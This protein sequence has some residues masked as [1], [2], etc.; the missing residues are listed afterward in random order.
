MIR[1]IGFGAEIPEKP[2]TWDVAVRVE[3]LSKRY[4]VGALHRR[5]D[6]LRDHIAYS[7]G[8]TLNRLLPGRPKE[9]DSVTQPA[10]WAI[11]DVS[12]EVNK[13]EVVGFIG[14]NGAGK[15][16]LLK[17]LSRVTKPTSGRAEIYGDSSSLLEVGTG[18]NGELTGRENT[19]LNGAILGMKKSEIDQ[20]FDDIVEFAEIGKF[21]DTPVKRYSSG[22]SVRLAFAVAAHMDPEILIVDEVL[23]VGDYR[24][25]EKCLGK[26]EDISSEGRTVLFVSHNMASISHLCDRAILLDGGRV[27]SDGPVSGVIEEYLNLDSSNR[28]EMH[29]TSVEDAPGTDEV[30]LRS[31]RVL[32]GGQGNAISEISTDKE[33]E[34]EIRFVVLREGVR[35]YTGIVL[36][37]MMGVPAFLSIN[38][39]AL[40]SNRDKW[41]GRPRPCGE[42]VAVCRIPANYLNQGRYSVTVL[43]GRVPLDQ[44]IYEENIVSFNTVITDDPDANY[45]PGGIVRPKMFWETQLGDSINNVS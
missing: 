31:V 30:R 14:R 41:Y 19:Y 24:F 20:K 6:T 28:S 8:T 3:S 12:F 13:G 22:M 33:I 1:R 15:S 34:I 44:T 23:A 16:T 7:F 36:D 11:K 21:I 32:Q 9:D 39:P 35:L 26:M 38:S 42:Y 27:V 37:G 25:Q 40:S 45:Y 2:D 5:H 18:F 29:W 43:L 4:R 17:I 10:I